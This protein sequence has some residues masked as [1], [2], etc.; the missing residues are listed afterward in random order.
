M[1]RSQESLF[2]EIR[3]G[4]GAPWILILL[5]KTS[6]GSPGGVGGEI[7]GEG[8]G[9]VQHYLAPGSGA[10]NKLCVCISP[11]QVGVV[12]LGVLRP[13]VGWAKYWRKGGGCKPARSWMAERRW[14]RRY[15][16]GLRVRRRNC[17]GGVWRRVPA[18]G[19]ATSAAGSTAVGNRGCSHRELDIGRRHGNYIRGGGW[20]GGHPPRLA[21]ELFVRRAGRGGGGSQGCCSRSTKN[22]GRRL[23]NINSLVLWEWAQG[24]ASGGGADSWHGGDAGLLVQVSSWGDQG[25]LDCCVSSSLCRNLKKTKLIEVYNLNYFLTCSSLSHQKSIHYQKTGKYNNNGEMKILNN[26][27]R[28][29][30]IR[31]QEVVNGKNAQKTWPSVTWKN[32]RE[33]TQNR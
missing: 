33:T 15:G 6:W 29:I 16:P 1:F 11:V 30:C 13:L 7:G 5:V 3:R 17:P 20:R 9:V 21:G 12:V 2:R 14:S 27:D 26:V 31:L 25:V 23:K 10:G 8:G 32:T 28:F 19:T 4:Q 22:G 24:G 18:G